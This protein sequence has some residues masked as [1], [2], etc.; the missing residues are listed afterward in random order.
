MKGRLWFKEYFP[1]SLILSKPCLTLIVVYLEMVLFSFLGY[2]GDDDM[3][4]EPEQSWRALIGYWWCHPYATDAQEKHQGLTVFLTF[5]SFFHSS[6]FLLIHPP[7][8][9]FPSNLKSHFHTNSAF[10]VSYP[11]N[12]ITKGSRWPLHTAWHCFGLMH[13]F[14]FHWED[15]VLYYTEYCCFVISS[16]YNKPFHVLCFCNPDDQ[17]L[18]NPPLRQNPIPRS[19][20][21][22]RLESHR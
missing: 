1:G 3:A 5:F 8:L 17:H 14:S 21:E 7:A 19:L 4:S 15:F 16:H 18:S 12:V 20:T 13:T 2:I 9:F 10:G 22:G 6:F 11:S